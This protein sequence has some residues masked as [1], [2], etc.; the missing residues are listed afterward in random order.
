MTGSPFDGLGTTIWKAIVRTITRRAKCHMCGQVF[1][2]CEMERDFL[3][4]LHCK[5]CIKKR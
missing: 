3:G 1:K 4:T 2:L 5:T